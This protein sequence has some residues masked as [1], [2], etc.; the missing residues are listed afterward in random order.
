MKKNVK[1]LTLSRET[2]R[3]LR[4]GRLSDMEL[5]QALGGVSGT[6]YKLSLCT[7]TNT[8]YCYLS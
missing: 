7:C 4:N 2:L 6:C 3:D 5:L 8:R 1:K